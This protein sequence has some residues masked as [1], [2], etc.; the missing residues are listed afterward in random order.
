[1]LHE[2]W[3]VEENRAQLGRQASQLDIGIE[4]WIRT[5]AGGEELHRPARDQQRL[6]SPHGESERV[7]RNRHGAH[8]G[9]AGDPDYP[10]ARARAVR[11]SGHAVHHL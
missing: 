10:E 3:L 8:G 2:R 11:S 1:M 5:P 7:L 6:R 4:R 9:K